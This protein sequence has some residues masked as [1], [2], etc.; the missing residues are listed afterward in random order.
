MHLENGMELPGEIHSAP[1]FIMPEELMDYTGTPDKLSDA[2]L[3]MKVWDHEDSC[4]CSY[5]LEFDK[6]EIYG[7]YK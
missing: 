6:R 7:E 2:D 5:C 4:D 1:K 3:V